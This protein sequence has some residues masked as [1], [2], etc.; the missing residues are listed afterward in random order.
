M[1][2]P[3]L[4]TSVKGVRTMH[5]QDLVLEVSAAQVL[6][7]QYLDTRRREGR[8]SSDHMSRQGIV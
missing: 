2:L 3:V 6:Y 1:M 5:L 8:H 7:L 4:S